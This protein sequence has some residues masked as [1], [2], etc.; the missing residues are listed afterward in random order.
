MPRR[1]EPR[2]PP[3][4]QGIR[5]RGLMTTRLLV[6][7]ALVAAALALAPA[8]QAATFTVTDGSS[9]AGPGTLRQAIDDANTTPGTD[10]IE[11][12]TSA[13]TVTTTLDPIV[14]PVT[15]DGGGSTVVREDPAYTGPL[16]SFQAGSAGSTL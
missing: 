15:V 5:G 13:I 6:L 8:A 12:A 2:R 7:A 9:D 11:F 3:L 4:V 14:D 1:E 10:T 16:L